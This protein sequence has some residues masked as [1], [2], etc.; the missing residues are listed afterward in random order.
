[1]EYRVIVAETVLHS[2][3]V[4]VDGPDSWEARTAAE[5]DAVEALAEAGGEYFLSVQDPTV[6]R[7]APVGTE[8]G[9]A[10]ARQ[11]PTAV[12]AR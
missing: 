5:A 12:R 7:V 2:V 8:A 3:P 11:V 4:H 9:H 1:M 6:L 10:S